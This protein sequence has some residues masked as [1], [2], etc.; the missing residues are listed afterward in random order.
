MYSPSADRRAC[1]CAAYSER[2]DAMQQLRVSN[3]V[4][5]GRCRELLAFCYFGIGIGFDEIRSAVGREAKVDTCVSIEP[6]CPVDTFR[7]SL[8]A[9]GHVWREVFGRP[10][11][12]SDA[13]LIVGIVLGLFGGD[14]PCALAA[15]IAE[16]QLPHRQNAQPVVA[17]H[18][19]VKFTSLDVLLG[20]GGG[21]EPI[22][23]ESDALCEFLVRIDDGRLRYAEGPILAQA[24]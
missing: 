20:N 9:G 3:S 22:V 17:E 2:Q 7:C 6:Q 23:N 10:I 1:L 18:A 19:D 13:R 4:M 16:F 11:D 5:L 24:L 8:D 14:L 12:D 21:L 15:Q